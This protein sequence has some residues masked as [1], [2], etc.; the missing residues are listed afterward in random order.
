MKIKILVVTSL[1]VLFFSFTVLAHD[2]GNRSSRLPGWIDDDGSH[3]LVG[4]DIKGADKRRNRVF[5]DIEKGNF[6][7]AAEKK[8][9]G[10][11]IASGFSETEANYGVQGARSHP[12]GVRDLKKA[13]ALTNELKRRRAA[14]LVSESEPDPEVIEAEQAAARAAMA[15]LLGEEGAAEI[16][17]G[18]NNK[19][20]KKKKKK[21]R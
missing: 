4:S 7:S 2:G 13:D 14:L 19:K 15:S 18:E 5:R 3:Q 12:N 21:K 10:D 16:L 20:K 17:D 1:M 11:F 6:R 8:L 9:Y